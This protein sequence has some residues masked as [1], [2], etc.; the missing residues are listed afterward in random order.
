MLKSENTNNGSIL[1]GGG[2]RL[3]ATGE[4]FSLLDTFKT[5]DC[6]FL[7]CVN[8]SRFAMTNHGCLRALPEESHG[9]RDPSDFILRMTVF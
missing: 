1:L 5:R 4:H 3:S 7:E 9:E 8:A 2:A 6:H